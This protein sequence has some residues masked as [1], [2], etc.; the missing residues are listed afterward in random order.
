MYDD[1][2]GVVPSASDTLELVF[3]PVDQLKCDLFA[4]TTSKGLPVSPYQLFGGERHTSSSTL[5]KRGE[6]ELRTAVRRYRLYMI[7]RVH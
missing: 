1:V 2:K 7:I 3:D 5:S 6:M 4:C